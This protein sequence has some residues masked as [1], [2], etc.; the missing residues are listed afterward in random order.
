MSRNEVFQASANN[1]SILCLQ[2]LNFLGV[3]LVTQLEL[4]SVLAGLALSC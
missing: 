3:I 2:S 1:A 4:V